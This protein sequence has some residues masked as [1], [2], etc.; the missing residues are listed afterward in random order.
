MKVSLWMIADRL[1]RYQPKV[2]CSD[3][4][5]N[6]SEIRISADGSCPDPEILYLAPS[7]LFFGG[8]SANIVCRNKDNY[9][10]LNTA[11]LPEALNQT[12]EAFG[13]FAKWDERCRDQILDGCSLPALLDLG[14]ELLEHPMMVVDSSQMRIANSG[15]F[16]HYRDTEEWAD[17][18]SRPIFPPDIMKQFNEKYIRT[19]EQKNL[20]YL[21]KDFFPTSC[22]CHHIW[23]GE[24]RLATLIVIAD[25]GSFSTGCLQMIELIVSHLKTWVTEN[26]M[27]DTQTQTTSDLARLLDDLPEA[28]L[29]LEKRLTAAGWDP[30]SPKQLFIASYISAYFYLEALLSRLLTE[31]TAGIYAIPYDKYLVVLCNYDLADPAAF[32]TNF[33]AFLQKN[34]Y[35]AACSFPF[36]SLRQIPDAYRQTLHT[37]K[38]AE[39]A[40][41]SVYS[42]THNAIPYI[43]DIV[44]RHSL[45]DLTHPLAAELRAYDEAHQ[46][47]YF[48]TL[49]TYLKNERN[50]Q[51]T[52]RELYIHR[53][54][55][56][57]R[58]QKIGELWD[59]SLEDPNERFYLLYSFFQIIYS[60]AK[61]E[62]V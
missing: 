50:H 13:F 39:P 22:W 60:D 37:L 16:E 11:D 44:R 23:A 2:H 8:S 26:R 6:I 9:L 14:E 53:N 21:P 40:A 10:L 18:M 25:E 42:E 52:A 33:R 36:R 28:D 38:L 49:F 47:D 45:L 29:A 35:Y 46:T 59:L 48:H 27:Q 4:E 58:L 62:T 20:F 3:K 24:R 51:L 17:N 55:L 30:N 34:N 15:G 7:G 32:R 41:G 54:T 19:F 1:S 56:F 57:K 31:H 61:K 12:L 5:R 43:T